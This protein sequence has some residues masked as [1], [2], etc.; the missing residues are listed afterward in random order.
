MTRPEVVIFD[1]GKVLL[2]FDYDLAIK[3]ILAHCSLTSEELH[4]LVNQS[5]LLFRFET[6]LMS[7]A[8][9][10]S[11]VQAA[12]RY[13]GQ[14]DE[15]IR[16]FADIFSPIDSM[17]A[18]Q[19]ELKNAGVPTYIFS[20]TNEL[21]INHIR[22]K[23]PF[24]NGFN[25]YFLSYEERMM[26]PEPKLYEIVE[27]RLNLPGNALLYIDDRVENV[28]AGRKRGWQAVHH[29]S[30]PET[31]SMVRSALSLDNART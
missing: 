28:E 25:G 3:G 16:C 10:Y 24:F 9:F 4:A 14:Q 18:L 27:R 5:P 2:D 8:E 20:N 22:S 26:K 6:G 17:I 29:V 21:A 11:E 1:L 19:A 7:T 12:S 31:I 23:Y 30:A 15:F 13:R